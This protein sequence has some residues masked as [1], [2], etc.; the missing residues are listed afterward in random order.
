MANAATPEVV[1]VD[2]ED[3]ENSSQCLLLGE[4]KAGGKISTVKFSREV[5]DIHRAAG[6]LMGCK[7]T[8]NI[9]CFHLPMFDH[10]DHGSMIV[11]MYLDLHGIEHRQGHNTNATQMFLIAN[12][13]A[14][15]PDV[16]PDSIHGPVLLT[17]EHKSGEFI[18]LDMTTWLKMKEACWAIQPDA[19]FLV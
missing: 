5:E 11:H 14:E 4:D 15:P 10:E 16:Q 12:L 6:R 8:D 9:R 1:E 19:Q 3:F 7:K 13:P 18:Q 2:E 17:A